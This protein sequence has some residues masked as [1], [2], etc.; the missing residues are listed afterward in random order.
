MR[1]GEEGDARGGTSRTHPRIQRFGPARIDNS[2][3]GVAV[4]VTVRELM[5]AALMFGS[6]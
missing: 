4:T 3:Q 5:T 1:T 6:T 2:S